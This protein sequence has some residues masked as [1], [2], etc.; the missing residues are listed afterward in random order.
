MINI[1]SNLSPSGTFGAF[2]PPARKKSFLPYLI[3]IGAVVLILAG[4]YYLFIFQGI[5]FSLTAGTNSAATPLTPTE[6]KVSQL[7]HFQFDV[8]D[9]PFYKSLKS[10]GAL[11]VAAD[12][13]GR[14]NPFIPF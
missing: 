10:Y 12:S 8:F 3:I 7:P 13:L 4:G 5:K 6:I 1:S 14:S 2:K 9:S 11:P